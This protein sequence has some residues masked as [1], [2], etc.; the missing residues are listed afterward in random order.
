MSKERVEA[1]LTIGP[2]RGP[3][4]DVAGTWHWHFFRCGADYWIC[5]A[6]S[7]LRVLLHESS[8][9]QDIPL[10]STRPNYGGIRWWFLCPKCRRRVAQLHK[11]SNAHHFFC[12]YCH[13]LTY[14]SAQSSGT[15]RWSIFQTVGKETHTATREVARWLRLENIPI[16]VH[17]VKRPAVNK[18]RDRRTGFALV[19]TK[20]ARRKGLSL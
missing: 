12:R 9:V 6:D 17:E 18:V 14:E 7:E 4:R 1:C 16:Y 3:L 20:E 5:T 8:S 2:P 11:P 19:V 13:N 15:K 10:S